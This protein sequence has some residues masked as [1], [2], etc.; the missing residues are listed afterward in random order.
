MRETGGARRDSTASELWEQV[1]PFADN[2]CRL[3]Q[4]G[5]VRFWIRRVSDE[6]FI[7]MEETKENRKRPIAGEEAPAPAGLQW[8]R[9]VAGKMA[10]IVVRPVLPDRPVVIKPSSAVKILPGKGSR[11][12][13][14]LPVW[15]SITEGS[16]KNRTALTEH[17]GVLL[18]STWFGN[19]DDGELCYS[20]TTDLYKSPEEREDLPLM[21]VCP[22]TIRNGSPTTL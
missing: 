1:V 21:A 11:Y 16:V 19:P 13:I 14:H 22:L 4:I 3:W 7:A 8:N 15:V 10:K 18:S 5:F 6:W 2:Q 17:P 12:F 9:Y 20:F